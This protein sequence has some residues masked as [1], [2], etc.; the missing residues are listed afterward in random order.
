MKHQEHEI[1][2]LLSLTEE[3]L[4][5]KVADHLNFDDV[6]YAPD[7]KYVIGKKWFDS[8]M[9]SLQQKL[10]HEW[11]I[12]EKMD[13]PQ[14]QDMTNFISVIADILSTMSLGIP[15]TLIAVLIVKM[16]IRKFCCTSTTE[17]KSISN[18]F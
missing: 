3:Q 7:V 9:K 12:A 2:D 8:K 14:Y 15:A 17:T 1:V 6:L 5:S 11:N 4:L 16:G 10:C 18:H 13:L